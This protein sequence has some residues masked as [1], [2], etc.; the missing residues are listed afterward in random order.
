M[1]GS[2]DMICNTLHMHSVRFRVENDC[3]YFRV[4]GN[5]R[6]K[7]DCTSGDCALLSV[8]IQ[9]PENVMPQDF[10]VEGVNFK[11]FQPLV[12]RN[13]VIFHALAPCYSMIDVVTAYNTAY[14][15]LCGKTGN[16][17]PTASVPGTVVC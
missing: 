16:V 12:T 11:E 10:A 2:L 1:T 15:L 8:Y 3:V 13:G 5:S 17:E 9:R 4:N 6:W 14:S 7:F